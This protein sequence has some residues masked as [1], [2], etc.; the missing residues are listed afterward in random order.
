MPE[1]EHA[2]VIV[3]RGPE[4]APSLGDA[5]GRLVGRMVEDLRRTRAARPLREQVAEVVLAVEEARHAST[6][7]DADARRILAIEVEAGVGEGFGRRR[8]TDDVGAREAA[9]QGGI[10]ARGQLLDLGRE[11]GAEARRVEKRD[12]TD[13]APPGDE[14]FPGR[15]EVVPEGGH[16]PEAR[17]DDAASVHP[18]DLTES[19]RALNC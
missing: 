5:V 18:P 16:G 2:V 1:D 14:P 19:R 9:S 3:E 11:L 15:R 17:H 12:G 6:E 4:E 10:E 13:A 8:E 7:D